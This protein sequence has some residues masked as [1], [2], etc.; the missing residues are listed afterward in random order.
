MIRITKGDWDGF[1]GLVLNNFVN[2]LL[3][4][5]LSQAVLGF[6]N[7]LIVYRILPGMAL[8]I[9]CG[10]FYYSWQAR[11]MAQKYGRPFAALPYGINL[12]P[13]FFYTF[14]VMLPAQ[15]IALSAGADKVQADNIAWMAGV[16]AC[17]GSGLIEVIGSW[18]APF[19][20]KVTPRAALL[21]ALAAVGLFFIAADYTFRSYAYPAIGLPTFFL[22]LY[23]FYGSVKMRWNLPGGLIVL[24]V[25]VSTA[26]ITYWLGMDSPVAGLSSSSLSWG[27][28]VPLP[29]GLQ[30]LVEIN[31]M[32][33][34]SAVILPMGLIN[35]LGSLQC[36]ESAEAAGDPY[37]IK[38]SLIVNGLGTVVAGGFGSPFPTTVYIGHPGWKELGARSGYSMINGVVIAALCFTGTLGLLS[39]YVPIEAGMAILIWIGFTISSQA[40]QVVPKSHAPAVIAGL[41]P[42]M[43]A[44]V[45]LITKR[46]LGATGYGGSEQ[47]YSN[48]VLLTLTQEGSLFAKGIF[49]LEQGWLF[50]S[51]VLASVTVA[52]VDRKFGN[53]LTWLGVA[54]LLS[55]M[56][57]IHNF[58]VLENDIT[59]GLGPAWPWIIGYTASLLILALVRYTLVMHHTE[60]SESD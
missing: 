36:L 7:D 46:V 25:G 40:F 26:W 54:G 4:I 43:G 17:L 33:A 56:G 39:E 48:E 47:P 31:Q 35:L 37:P 16:L 24:A 34:F 58:R 12:L 29:Y 3:I 45:A 50:A 53:I 2:L 10:N 60:K 51:V 20:K 32:L 49:A 18:F 15:Q 28:Y 8:G 1:F 21:S 19:L 14:Y 57:I 30:A 23:L 55:F 22:T 5:S 11:T 59:T 44:F 52:I 38:Q 41:I 9:L 6:S 27:L 13:I 42:G